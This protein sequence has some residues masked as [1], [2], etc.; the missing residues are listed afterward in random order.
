MFLTCILELKGPYRAFVDNNITLDNR[1]WW[2]A[3]RRFNK[4][5]FFWFE[6]W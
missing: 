6:N 1:N 4:K 3:S 5:L 2:N